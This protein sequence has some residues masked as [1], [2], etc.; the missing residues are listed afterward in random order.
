[1]T[2]DE[3]ATEALET[4]GVALVSG[5]SFGNSAKNFVRFSFANSKDNILKAME[6]LSKMVN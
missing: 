5:S 3:F 2:G 4:Y 1:M 6:I